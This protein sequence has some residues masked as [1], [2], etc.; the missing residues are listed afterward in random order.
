MEQFS[1]TGNVAKT[2]QSVEQKTEY[3]KAPKST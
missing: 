2:R 3:F 1:L